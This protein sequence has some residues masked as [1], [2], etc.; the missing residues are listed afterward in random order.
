MHH[1]LARTRGG[2]G[3]GNPGLR[4]ALATRKGWTRSDHALV[5][6]PVR[7]LNNSDASHARVHTYT[8]THHLTHIRKTGHPLCTERRQPDPIADR[9]VAGRLRQPVDRIL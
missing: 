7:I 8:H 5:V 9:R 1:G 6:A 2:G 3:Q 4:H